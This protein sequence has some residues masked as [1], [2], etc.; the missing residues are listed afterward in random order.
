M[1]NSNCGKRFFGKIRQGPDGMDDFQEGLVPDMNFRPA[2][3]F[4]HSD[5]RPKNSEIF[6]HFPVTRREGM[7]Y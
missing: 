3:R 6:F 4:C 1:E 5:V 7:L 2:V